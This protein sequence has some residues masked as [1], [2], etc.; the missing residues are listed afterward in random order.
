MSNAVNTKTQD[1]VSVISDALGGNW[2]AKYWAKEG[3][4]RAY[5]YDSKK[6]AGYITISH[7][8]T[9]DLSNA[10]LASSAHGKAE[11]WIAAEL[12]KLSA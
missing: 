12:A 11:G 8:G 1:L 10:K 2:S 3:I 9:V 5:L 4:E 7:T 6:P